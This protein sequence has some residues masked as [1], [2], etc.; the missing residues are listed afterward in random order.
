MIQPILKASPTFRPVWDE[1][2]R[3]WQS[4]SDEL[5]LY[6][7]LSDLARHMAQLLSQGADSE[8]QRIF[9]VVEEWHLDGNAYVKEAATVGLIEDLQNTN[10][11]GEG[12]PAEL[13]KFLGPESRRWWEKVENFWS[14][15][16]LIQDD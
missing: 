2:L 8:L 4:Q 12:A 15:G 7:V 6:L 5:P 16:E 13:A 11:V 10:L 9:A 1:F 3:Q 14:K